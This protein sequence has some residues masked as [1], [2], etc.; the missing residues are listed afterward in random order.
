MMVIKQ[1]NK[2]H[3]IMNLS[4]PQGAS[5]NDAINK[6]A[7]EKVVM[8]TAKTLSH[9]IADCSHSAHMWKCDLVDTYK[10]IPA[11]LTDL[12]IQAFSWLGMGF[13]ETQTKFFR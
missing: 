13:V 7:L 12:R 1:K 2:V 10:N 3:V 8:S 6:I 5:H 4:A 9:S 11:T